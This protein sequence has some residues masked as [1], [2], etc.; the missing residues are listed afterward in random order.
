MRPAPSAPPSCA[1][2]PPIPQMHS[3]YHTT[4]HVVYN[5]SCIVYHVIPHPF[6]TPWQAL[7]T[8]KPCAWTDLVGGQQDDAVEE[9]YVGA[10]RDGQ[11]LNAQTNGARQVAASARAAQPLATR[12]RQPQAL[13][14]CL[15]QSHPPAALSPARR[16]AP[17]RRS[18]CRCGQ[19]RPSPSPCC[20]AGLARAAPAVARREAAAACRAGRRAAAAGWAAAGAGPAGR[21]TRGLRGRAA[22]GRA[23]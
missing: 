16:P 10:R 6:P 15:P 4:I 3:S 18:P 5:I 7:G 14:S 9:G 21:C 19:P 8:G 17:R 1:S 2:R 13:E 12:A 11:H 22:W 20:C 23:G